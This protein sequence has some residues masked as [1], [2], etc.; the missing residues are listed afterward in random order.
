MRLAELELATARAGSEGTPTRLRRA[1]AHRRT[2]YSTVVDF[3]ADLLVHGS[4]E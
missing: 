4:P 2:R 3:H 1:R